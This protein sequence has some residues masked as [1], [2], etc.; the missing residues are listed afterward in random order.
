VSHFNFAGES[1]KSSPCRPAA[2]WVVRG[3]AKDGRLQPGID[4]YRLSIAN[5]S[6]KLCSINAADVKT[7]VSALLG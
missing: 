2:G 3:K 5:T 4:N 1:W 6:V 7:T